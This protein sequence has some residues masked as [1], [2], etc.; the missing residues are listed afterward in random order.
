MVSP[1]IHLHNQAPSQH[2]Q[3]DQVGYQKNMSQAQNDFY[4]YIPQSHHH[5][6]HNMH[7][8]FSN[9]QNF[10]PNDSIS[11]ITSSLSPSN[12]PNLPMPDTPKNYP[13]D[14]K[15]EKVYVN[16]QEQTSKLESPLVPKTEPE[17]MQEIS[18]LKKKLQRNRTSFSQ[19]QIEI[20][21]HGK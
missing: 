13:I 6:H 21:E 20:L 7:H 2:I 19:H 5:H 9:S 17:N 4:G 14:V 10:F 8:H 15:H 16:H 11:S 1:R 18:K 3:E 12:F